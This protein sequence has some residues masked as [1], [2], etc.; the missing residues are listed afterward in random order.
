[1][2]ESD[3]LQA[4]KPK[5]FKCCLSGSL[6]FPDCPRNH[7]AVVIGERGEGAERIKIRCAK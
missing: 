6:V 4:S 2:E 7:E 3:G 1:M 5:I